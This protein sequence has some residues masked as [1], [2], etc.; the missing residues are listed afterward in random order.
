MKSTQQ[1]MEA[2]MD[3]DV[4][5]LSITHIP[6]PIPPPHPPTLTPVT[7]ANPKPCHNRERVTPQSAQPLQFISHKRVKIKSHSNLSQHTALHSQAI[8]GTLERGWLREG[9]GGKRA[10]GQTFTVKPLLGTSPVLWASSDPLLVHW[11][12]GSREQPWQKVG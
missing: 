3:M 6:T 1:K 11:S 10:G 12:A 8:T 4:I 5:T 7:T 9:G 2:C